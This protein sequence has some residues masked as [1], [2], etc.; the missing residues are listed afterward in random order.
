MKKILLT[1]AVTIIIC[2]GVFYFYQ[3]SVTKVPVVEK[4]TEGIINSANFSCAENKTIQAIFFKDRV[5]LTLSDG[6]NMLIPQGVSGSGARYAN[7]DESF[8]FWNKGDTAFVL[9]GDKTTFTD[10]SVK[11]Q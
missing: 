4:V 10:C 7:T 1:V 2:L 6:R 9:E 5:E 3:K 11:V 8:V